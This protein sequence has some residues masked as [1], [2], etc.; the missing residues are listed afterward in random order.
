[1]QPTYGLGF[2]RLSVERALA[3]ASALW[4]RLSSKD[5]PNGFVIFCSEEVAEVVHPPGPLRRRLYSCGRHFNTSVLRQA[6][7]AEHGAVYGAIVIDGVEATFGKVQGLCTSSG[8]APVVTKVGHITSTTAARTRRG[9]QSALRYSR[10]RDE[11]ELA[12]LRK[13]AETATSLFKDVSALIVAG[14][15]DMKRKLLPELS[16]TLRGQVVCCIDLSGSADMDGLRHAARAAAGAAASR[17]YSKSESVVQHFL[18]LTL[19]PDVEEVRCCYGKSQTKAALKLGAVHELLIATDFDCSSGHAVEDWKTLAAENGA[20][21]L[22]IR[23]RG[24]AAVQFCKSFGIGACLRWPVLA[25]LLDDDG[26]AVVAAADDGAVPP[27]PE[28]HHS[29]AM[30]A[31]LEAETTEQFASTLPAAEKNEQ[32]SR[33]EILSWLG[34]ELNSVF[35]PS[36]AEALSMCIE[37]ILLDETTATEEA[38]LQAACVLQDEGAPRGL[39]AALEDRWRAAMS[40]N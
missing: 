3:R 9:G 26:V 15:A 37:V 18:E 14:K 31:T 21:F 35:D 1:M 34:S 27:D 20:K 22:E 29:P 19:M 25:G 39:C 30:A 2:N 32:E 28:L 40:D 38:L 33:T 4:K 23:P 11:S 13:V 16:E 24:E 12:F 36:A 8:S 5:F 10:L 17:E 7:E 6:V